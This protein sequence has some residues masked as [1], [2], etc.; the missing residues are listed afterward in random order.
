MPKSLHSG[1]VAKQMQ[2]HRRYCVVTMPVGHS[3]PGS[4]RQEG[5]AQAT[6]GN[7]SCTQDETVFA[8]EPEVKDF[9][10]SQTDVATR[11]VTMLQRRI[12]SCWSTFCCCGN[13]VAHGR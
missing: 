8:V 13:G 2:F 4:M 1:W 6:A 10:E 3:G 5:P 12:G 7:I 11:V 9:N